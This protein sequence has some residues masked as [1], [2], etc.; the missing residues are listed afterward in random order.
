MTE[1]VYL[2]LI[3]EGTEVW[4]PVPAWRIDERRLILLRT[5]DYDA[6]VETWAFAPGTVVVATH[7]D[8]GGQRVLAVD[9]AAD[10]GNLSKAV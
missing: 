8:I 7:R 2:Q 4:R 1:Q 9:R 3:D 5:A 6:G 10:V